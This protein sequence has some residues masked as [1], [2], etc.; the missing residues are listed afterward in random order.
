MSTEPRT[1]ADTRMMGIVHHALRRDLVRT[2][3]ALGCEPPPAD[4]QREALAEHVEWLMKFL[5]GH[6]AGEDT[7]LYPLVLEHNP[8]AAELLEAMNAEHEGIAPCISEVQAAA[9]EYGRGDSDG[10]RQRLLVSIENLE[11]TLLPHLLREEEEMMPVV[12]ASITA[13]DWRA[14]DEE[15]NLK[16]KSF[17]E[18]GR[19]GHWIIDG[20]G[21]GDREVVLHVVPPIPR[22]ILLHGFARSYRHQQVRWWG[23]SF[24]TRRRVAPQGRAEVLVDAAADDVWE[25]VRDVTRVG[26]WS[27]E[28]VSA[29][30]RG[31]ATEAAPGA[32]FRGRNRAGLV[33]WGRECEIV[34]AEPRELVW[35]TVPSLLYPDSVEWTIRL[36]EADQGTRVEQTYQVLK[37]SPKILDVAFAMVVSGHRDRTDALTED[38]RR[39]GT[40]AA[41]RSGTA[42][43]QATGQGASSATAAPATPTGQ[44]VSSAG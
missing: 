11:K 21:K 34:S 37:P 17:V 43:S 40:L 26:E 20:L 2:R 6:H 33:R 1:P 7:G 31:G 28:C 23:E 8:A 9:A 41:H 4:D 18:L 14:W 15:Y 12:S 38:L 22:F 19:E 36:H 5:H 29:Q 27:H 3:V 42:G 35:R 24:R 30:W 13:A 39:L 44:G 16:T 25:V 10:Q 32:R